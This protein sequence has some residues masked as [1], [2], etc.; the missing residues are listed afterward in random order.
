MS[1]LSA[2]RRLDDR[3]M[4]PTPVA[5]PAQGSLLPYVLVGA[6]CAGFPALAVLLVD[7]SLLAAALLPLVG[8]LPLCIAL[9]LRP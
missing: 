7:G 9:L 6:V 1:P 2:L 8:L 5:V 3:V 4:G